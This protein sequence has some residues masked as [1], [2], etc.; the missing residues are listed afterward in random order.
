MN[1]KFTIEELA[2]WIEAIK[3]AAADDNSFSIA[4]FPGTEHEPFSIIAGW[5]EHFSD[6]SEVDDMFCVSASNPRYVMC[7]KIAENDG[8]YAYTDYDLMNMPVY[9]DSEVDDTEIILEWEDDS[10]ELAEFFSHEWERIM[11]TYGED[12]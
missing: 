7:I 12:I 2:D 4:W 3:D 9:D 11:E 1:T 8:P 6:N 10:E 5:M